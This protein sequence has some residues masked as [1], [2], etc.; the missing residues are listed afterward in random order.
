MDG[1]YLQR[2]RTAYVSCPLV[3]QI[4]YC[5]SC[6]K[7]QTIL[8]KVYWMKGTVTVSSKNLYVAP[9]LIVTECSHGERRVHLSPCSGHMEKATGA[10]GERSSATILITENDSGTTN[11]YELLGWPIKLHLFFLKN[12]I[13]LWSLL[14]AKCGKKK[15]SE[16][17]VKGESTGGHQ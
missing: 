2:W 8:S 4:S 12:N 15:K 3:W 9:V 16:A 1:S 17:G 11:T 10:S 13:F 6:F 7:G 5:R 14:R